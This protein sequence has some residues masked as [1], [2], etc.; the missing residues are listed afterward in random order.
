MSAAHKKRSR[1]ALILAFV[2]VFN[3]SFTM[4]GTKADA[5]TS[6][7][8]NALKNQ[9]AQLAQKKAAIQAQSQALQGQVNDQTQKLSI[10]AQQLDVTNQEM[11][12]LSQQ[13]AAYA[14]SIAQLQNELNIDE[15]KEQELLTQYGKRLRAMEENGNSSYVA[16]IFGASN[17]QDLLGRISDV[18]EI[19]QYDTDL[20]N[21]VREAEQKVADAKSKMETEMATQQDVFQ[22]YQAKQADLLSQQEEVKNVLATLQA[23]S[24]DY[25]TQLQSV[26]SLSTSIS[27]QITNMQAELEEQKRLQAEQAAAAQIANS[28]SG[29]SASSSSSGKSSGNKSSGNKWTNDSTVSGGSGQDIVNY[30]ESFLGVP[31]VYGGTSPSGFDCSGLVYYCYRHFGYAVNRTAASL[32]YN[33]TSVSSLRPGDVLLF[34]SVDGGYIGHCGIYIGGG[35]FIHAPHTGDVVKISNL[36]DSY[37]TSHYVGARRIIS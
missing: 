21:E 34:T 25:A 32:A 15:Q 28:N 19:M 2:M 6:S 26:N 14:D 4:L 23:N 36:S 12:N 10:L 1:L 13:I 29:K 16:I 31:Y 7:Q 11:E 5:V 27:S 9:Q 33:G 17:F 3:L 18:K 24:A 37:Y 22:Q 20:I 30:A 8:I 35:Q